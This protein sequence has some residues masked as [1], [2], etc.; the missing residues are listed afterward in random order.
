MGLTARL[1]GLN[2]LRENF[3]IDYSKK[4]QSLHWQVTPI[5][6]KAPFSTV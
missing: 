1:S 3:N 6:A 5:P 2:L 4:I